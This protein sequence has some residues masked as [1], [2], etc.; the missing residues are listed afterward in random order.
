MGNTGDVML[1]RLILWTLLAVMVAIAPPLAE[2]AESAALKVAYV[3]IARAI[4]SSMAATNAREMLKG[5]LD[6][7]QREVSAMESEIKEMK[8]DFEKRKG[9]LNP[10]SRAELDGRIRRK[11]REYQRLVEDNQ[12]ALDRENNRWTKKMTQAMSEVVEEVG[13][14][15][16]YTMIFAK[17]PRILYF[18]ES[19]DITDEV[20]SRFNK[21]TEGWFKK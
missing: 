21:R 11:F 2:A 13:R 9:L 4:D 10:E 5:K 16:G 3:D 19:V 1:R 15:R 8:A 14:E 20:L 12:A 7:K 18:N 6:A 17:N